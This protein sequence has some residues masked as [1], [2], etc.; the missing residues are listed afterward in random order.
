MKNFIT[1]AKGAGLLEKKV[2]IIRLALVTLVLGVILTAIFGFT[3]GNKVEFN[4]KA[5]G[6]VRNI[7]FYPNYQ[8]FKPNMSQY[9]ANEYRKDFTGALNYDDAEV[10]SGAAIGPVIESEGLTVGAANEFNDG[11]Y[12]VGWFSKKL[13]RIINPATDI[14]TKD[15]FGVTGGQTDFIGMW[16]FMPDYTATVDFGLGDAPEKYEL[17]VSEVAV[18]LPNV[19]PTFSLTSGLQNGVVEESHEFDGWYTTPNFADDTKTASSIVNIKLPYSQS[20]APLY[21]LFNRAD[22]QIIVTDSNGKTSYINTEIKLFAKWNVNRIYADDNVDGNVTTEYVNANGGNDGNGNEVVI[23]GS[24]ENGGKDTALGNANDSN[25][26]AQEVI[27]LKALKEKLL[28][29]D[30]DGDGIPAYRDNNS[31]TVGAAY[32]THTNT[33]SVNVIALSIASIIA[34]IIIGLMVYFFVTNKE[35]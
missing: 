9:N 1:N 23:G 13:A 26:T 29:L 5:D 25:N 28:A 33:D 34:F 20:Y 31:N 27:E 4:S 21:F 10:I 24:D 32:K 22:N 11:Y 3:S 35:E 2:L 8:A 16:D 18:D 15:M 19:L 30:K 12:F 6:E 7:M 14:I 17:Q